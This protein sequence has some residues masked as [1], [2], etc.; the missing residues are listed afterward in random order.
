MAWHRNYIVTTLDHYYYHHLHY[1]YFH[2]QIYNSKLLFI[3]SHNNIHNHNRIS[4]FTLG[5]SYVCLFTGSISRFTFQ[6]PSRGYRKIQFTW[7]RSFR[8]FYVS[9]SYISSSICEMTSFIE[10]Q[11]RKSI[12]SSSSS[13]SSSFSSLISQC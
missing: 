10:L 2:F 11:P 12:S 9:V 4:T 13:F 7:I 5:L 3:R 8:K 6:R 1:Y